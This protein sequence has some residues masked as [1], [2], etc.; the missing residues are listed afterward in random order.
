MAGDTIKEYLKVLKHEGK[1]I[2]ELSI[3]EVIRAYRKLAK[4]VHPDISGYASK[5]DF[6]ELGHAY[7]KML[8]ILVIRAKQNEDTE[9]KKN[10]EEEE[11]EEDI[12]EKFVK[13]NF[14]NFNLPT[15]KEGSFIVRVE[16]DLA[17]TWDECFQNLYGEPN[18]V[19]NTKTGAE[20]SRLWRINY[21]GCELTIHLYKKPKTTKI[22]KFLVQGGS[23]L[24]KYSFV[25]TELPQIYKKVCEAKPIISK[26][27]NTQMKQTSVTCDQCKF[28]SISMIQMKKH[29]KTIHNP[30]RQKS[31]KRIANFTPANKPSKILKN[32]D[33][34]K[35][36]IF[37]NAEGIADESIFMVEESCSAKE[38]ENTLEEREALGEEKQVLVIEENA[39]K[40]Q[41]VFSCTKCDYETEGEEILK[42]HMEEH[43]KT[44][45]SCSFSKDEDHI[46][47]VH[48]SECKSVTENQTDTA[49][50]INVDIKEV[51]AIPT[52]I[53]EKESIRN[54]DDC[55]KGFQDMKDFDKHVVEYHN[56]FPCFE[57]KICKNEFQFQSQL[58]EHIKTQHSDFDRQVNNVPEECAL[59]SE[60]KEHLQ[61]HMNTQH[62]TEK[63]LNCNQC[64]NNFGDIK[65]LISHIINNHSEN[66]EIIHCPHCDYKAMDTETIDSHIENMHV[67]LA[68]LGHVTTNQAILS[69]NYEVFKKDLTVALNAII[70]G[71]NEMKQELFILR[72][73]YSES[74]DKLETIENKM[75]DLKKLVNSDTV[76]KTPPILDVPKVPQ[77]H[78]VV[79][80]ENS[81]NMLK[82][83]G[84]INNVLFVGDSITA[85]AHLPTLVAAVNADIKQVRAYSSTFENIDSPASL[86]PRFP[87]KNFE[88]II[89]NEVCNAKYDA[90]IV[91]SGSVDVTNLKTDTNDAQ[92]YLEYFKQKTIVSAQNLFQAVT[93]A[94]TKNPVLKK[95]VL[96]EQI[97]RHDRN[98]SNPPGLKPYLSSIFNETLHNLCDSE[99]NSRVIFGKHNLECHGAV[100]EAR[101]R[102]IQSNKFDGIHLHGPS[103]MKAYTTSVL[104]I[105][106]S[107]QLVVRCP[108][109]YY[110]QLEHMRCPQ[111]KYQAAQKYS[112][113]RS[114]AHTRVQYTEQYRVQRGT[115]QNQVQNTEQCRPYSSVAAVPTYNRYDC[116]ANMQGNY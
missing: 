21:Q 108:P 111:A 87:K 114:T 45:C 72:Q 14:H 11:D 113:Q 52:D 24:K 1:T 29:L 101:Y 26:I 28:K 73:K 91:Q 95:V 54:C 33:G 69:Q 56:K 23:H 62:G 107:A 47:K 104:N 116:L 105:L 71:H 98:T 63:R 78:R 60:P 40:Q 27:A 38:N 61:K 106:S 93:N 4:T 48:D 32:I 115:S 84:K 13:E 102:N 97:P 44:Q 50:K 70:E 34:P 88:D 20:I 58:E 77:P 57:C 83:N 17:D 49:N 22:S 16:N 51:D 68:L 6:Q 82:E 81:K 41:I 39:V 31:S 18:K 90:L 94:A 85:A 103:G 10:M 86:A 12:D 65:S 36:N 43:I 79:K 110:D 96:M 109:K 99:Q 19:N 100:L 66:S 89:A 55:S 2:E 92:N 7:E 112:A 76:I 42:T 25:F 80:P 35:A 46:L 37:L 53:G 9:V 74:N 30:N 5:E 67:E 59:Q 64:E 15:E 75:E 3:R 8:E